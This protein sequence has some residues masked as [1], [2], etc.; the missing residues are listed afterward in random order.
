MI[1]CDL[2]MPQM[3]GLQL[4][5]ELLSLAPAQAT[6]TI[7]MTGGSISPETR[8][9]LDGIPNLAKPFN[10]DELRSMIATVRGRA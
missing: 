3:S 4:H 7:L 10:L 2:M 5:R 1:L 8:S 9:H 6:A